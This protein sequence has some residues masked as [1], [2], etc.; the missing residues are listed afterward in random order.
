MGKITNPATISSEFGIDSAVLDKLGVVNV[1]LNTDTL[2]FIDPLLLEGSA[3]EEI[4]DGAYQSYRARFEKIIKLLAVSKVEVV[5]FMDIKSNLR[6]I[7]R[8][9]TQI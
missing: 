2:V 9:T 1:L 7:K 4:S 5:W 6:S 8:Q 3:H